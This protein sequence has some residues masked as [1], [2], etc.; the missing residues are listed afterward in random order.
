MTFNDSGMKRARI[1]SPGRGFQT[2][3]QIQKS[4][5]FWPWPFEKKTYLLFH[6]VLLGDVGV[7]FHKKRC[8]FCVG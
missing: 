8:L 3:C 5:T 7:C 4:L 6:L 2:H 1:E